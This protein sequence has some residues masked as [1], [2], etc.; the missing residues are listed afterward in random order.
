MA[1]VPEW[2][3]KEC[4]ER[5]G[6]EVFFVFNPHKER[7]VAKAYMIDQPGYTHD[8]FYVEDNMR[9]YREI[10]ME[11][12]YRCE[13]ARVIDP[14][15]KKAAKAKLEAELAAERRAKIDKP[16]S[17]KSQIITEIGTELEKNPILARG[18]VSD[19]KRKYSG[20]KAR[21]VGN[22]VIVDGGK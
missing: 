20:I 12:I 6:D 19:A 1:E 21:S 14:E 9:R 3:Q 2:V 10:T 18:F 8:I 15:S 4:K 11:D 5:F 13:R 16:K 22:K 17:K 7:F